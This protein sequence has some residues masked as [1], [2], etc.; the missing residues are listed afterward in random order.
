MGA[1]PEGAPIEAQG[2]GWKNGFETGVGPQTTTSGIVG[3]WA[4]NPTTWDMG[5]LDTLLNNE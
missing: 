4:P 5:Y 2:F 3:A 1:E